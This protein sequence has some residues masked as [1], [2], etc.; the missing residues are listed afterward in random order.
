MNK[1]NIKIKGTVEDIRFRN[2]TNGYSVIDVATNDNIHTCVGMLPDVSVGEILEISGSVIFDKKYGAQINVETC[3]REIPD[4][5]DGLYKYLASGAI[6]KVGVKRAQ[7]IIKEFGE[8]SFDILLNNPERLS[9]IKGISPAVAKEIGNSYRQ[10]NDMHKSIIS[11]ERLGLTPRECNAAFNEFKENAA[12]AVSENP[13]ILTQIN[14]NI[15]FERADALAAKLLKDP[16]SKLRVRACIVHILKHNFFDNG[17]TFLPR[18]KLIK[19]TSGYL[20]INEDIVDIEIDELEKSSRL[21]CFNEENAPVFLIESYLCEKKIADRIKLLTA[22]PPSNIKA[23]ENDISELQKKLNITYAKKQKTA[24]ITAVEKGILVLTG[25]PGTGKTTTLHGILKI[26]EKHHIDVALAAPTGRAAK[27]MSEI[28]GKSASTIHRLLEVQ[29]DEN[30]R[31]T[32]RRNARNPLSCSALI[33]DEMSMVDITLFASLCDALPMSCR[34]IMLGDSNQLPAVGPGN[35]LKDL[36]SSKLLPVIELDTIFRQAEN[37][38]IIKNSHRIVNGQEI[39][40]GSKEDNF[41][42]IS[43]ENPNNTLQTIASLFEKRLPKA[44]KLNP[45]QDI[46][47]L[48]PSKKS[49]TGT[50]NLNII[51]QNIINPRQNKKAELKFGYRLFRVGD[52]VMQIKNNYDIETEDKDGNTDN[53]IFN[54]DI[55]L[56]TD[57]DKKNSELII[58]F[59]GKTAK[60]PYELLD[61]LELAYAI[62]IH[63]SQGNEFNTVIMPLN[64]V[65]PFLCYRNLLYT[66][67]TRAKRLMIVIGQKNILESMINN[68]KQT[69]RY[70]YLKNLLK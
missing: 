4:D 66:G 42:F 25:G 61:E 69:K 12:N 38:L 2:D 35:I 51:L 70:S 62:T 57:I 49:E 41:F 50:A 60:Y 33:I 17:H 5:L 14:A 21:K 11:L 37:S 54:G 43:S 40:S 52:K 8:D 63:K 67:I 22:F 10:K 34:L 32:Y 45:V 28:T 68:N 9:E 56:I 30:G 55:G 24:V 7:T 65:S 29:T 16:K 36:I 58:D 64:T 53:G 1:Q 48:C 47:I 27:R 39:S 19:L 44:Y 20:N 13:Y 46:Q 31:M 26:F 18:N 23:L 15:G 3:T 59:E 6:A